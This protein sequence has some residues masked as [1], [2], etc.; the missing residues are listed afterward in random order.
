MGAWGLALAASLALHVV[1]IGIMAILGMGGGGKGSTPPPPVP[2]T[3]GRAKD[4]PS[5]TDVEQ[6]VA[7]SSDNSVPSS[8]NEET[9]R[10]QPGTKGRQQEAKRS[11]KSERT[12]SDSRKVA[13][14]KDDKD[15]PEESA[16]D[17]WKSYKVKSGDS[18]SKIARA[19]GCSVP[20]LA[21]ANGLSL[22]TSLKLGQVIKVKN[23]PSDAE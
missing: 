1:V 21:K 9:V 2:Q 8:V 5:S 23:M 19:C 20:E 16:K 7:S 3:D 10:P 22:T 6:P 13:A 11:T 17:G 18:L 4:L 14:A 12:K 15:G